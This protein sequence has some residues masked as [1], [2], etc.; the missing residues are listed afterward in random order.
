M[1]LLSSYSR[2]VDI[3]HDRDKW[4]D[5]IYSDLKKTFDKAPHKKPIWKMESTGVLRGRIKEWMKAYLGGKEIRT[6]TQT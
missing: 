3:T 6:V 4:A 5:C 1:S 2:A